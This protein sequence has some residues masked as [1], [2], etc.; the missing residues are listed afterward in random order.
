M[1]T[2]FS[3]FRI[4]FYS[5]TKTQQ[6]IYHFVRLCRHKRTLIPVI[7]KTLIKALAPIQ[8][9]FLLLLSFA[10]FLAHFFS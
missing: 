8:N 6:I 10:I 5:E 2:F 3:S 4:S 1:K 9:L 7:K